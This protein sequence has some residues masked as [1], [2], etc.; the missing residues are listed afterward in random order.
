MK[1]RY[2]MMVYIFKI[3]DIDLKKKSM[4]NRMNVSKDFSECLLLTVSGLLM[5]KRHLSTGYG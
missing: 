3:K 4:K 1:T 5:E 2:M